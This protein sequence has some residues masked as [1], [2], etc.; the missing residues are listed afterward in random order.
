M[1]DHRRQ[2]YDD[3]TCGTPISSDKK[4]YLKGYREGLENK[5]AWAVKEL[6][7]FD[8]SVCGL[9]RATI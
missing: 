2:G 6:R 3:A 7:E 4:E 9:Y 5:L 1:I 8:N